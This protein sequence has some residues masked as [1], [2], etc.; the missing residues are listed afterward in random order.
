MIM[1]L[2]MLLLATVL[3]LSACASGQDA[4]SADTTNHDAAVRSQNVLDEA[5]QAGAPGCSA[6]VGVE[7]KVV[8]TGVRGV[9]DMSTGNAIT[10]HTVFDIASVTKQFPA[11]GLLLLVDAGKLTLDDPLSRYLPELPTWATTITVG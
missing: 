2:G 7:G 4:T 9:S 3:W 11:S 8:W 1:R 10:T 5:I 6:A